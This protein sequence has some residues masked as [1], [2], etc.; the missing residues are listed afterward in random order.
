MEYGEEVRKQTLGTCEPIKVWVDPETKLPIRMESL[1]QDNTKGPQS[2]IYDFAFDQ[3]LDP[4]LF[5]FDPPEGYKVTT[6]GV[7][8]LQPPPDKP[9]LLAPEVKPGVGLGPVQFGMSRE[10][11]I[12]LLGKPDADLPGGIEYSSRGYGFF[13]GSKGGVTGVTCFSQKSSAFK[14]RDFAGRTKEGMGIGSSLKDLENAFGK[15]DSV[16][17]NRPGS[18]CFSVRYN[19]LGLDL[20]LWDDKVVSFMMLPMRPKAEEPKGGGAK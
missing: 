20:T 6:M 10:E 19:E 3:P 15:A 9:E 17:T 8:N 5:S 16:E 18:E 11:V 12:E 4:A 1:T 7:A 13:I 2:A 14:V